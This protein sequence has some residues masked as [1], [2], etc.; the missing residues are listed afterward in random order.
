MDV[1]LS[2]EDVATLVRALN[3]LAV[4]ERI[5]GED[6]SANRVIGLSERIVT[7]LVT[8]AVLTMAGSE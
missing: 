2:A 1:E 6:I 4:R 8:G 3:L 5:E 7:V